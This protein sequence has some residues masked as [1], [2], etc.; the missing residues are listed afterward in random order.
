MTYADT[1]FDIHPALTLG[2]IMLF[3]IG[4]LF[5]IKFDVGVECEHA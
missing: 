4:L 1:F 2:M 5:L 3:I